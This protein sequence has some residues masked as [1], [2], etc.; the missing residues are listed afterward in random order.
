MDKRH[1]HAECGE[2]E[3]DWLSNDPEIEQDR[4]DETVV[5]E[6]DDPGI[7]PDH[8]SKKQRG[9][10]NHEQNGFDDCVLG[11]NQR[12]GQRIADD[13][14]R[15]R[16]EKADPHRVKKHP[17]IKRLQQIGKIHKRKAARIERA[18]DIGTQAELEHG[19]HRGEKAESAEHRRRSED[20]KEWL[21]R[22]HGSER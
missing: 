17:R 1:D 11:T 20:T 6:N 22:V 15:E 5:A 3:L 2:H 21:L 14:R 16:G 10:D 8:F 12:I 19:R 18:G 7:G 4:I 13:Q 9:D